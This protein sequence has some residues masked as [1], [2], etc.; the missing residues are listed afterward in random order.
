MVKYISIYFK[1][2]FHILYKTDRK[3]DFMLKMR[4]NSTVMLAAFVAMFIM[5]GCANQ[6]PDMTEDENALVT[7]Y[8][9]GLLLKYHADYEGR[10]VDTA[11]PPEEK[12]PVVPEQVVDEI[13]PE[14]SEVDTSSEEVIVS[15]NTIEEVVKPTMSIAQVIGTE[16]FDVK[17]RAFE[18]CDRYPNT[19]SSPEELFFSMK[20]GQGNKLL[21][22]KID[23]TNIG[24]EEMIF[25]TLEK[26]DMKCKV[27]INGSKKQ[28]VYISMLENDFMAMNHGIAPGETIEAAV[29]T[30]LPE[31][32]AQQITDA[33]LLI[34]NEGR[35]TEVSVAE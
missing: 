4:K 22:L 21:V 12:V 23:I 1:W 30:E 15:S 33:K 24:S 13:L 35:S 29:I 16:G 19:E 3:Q 7:E 5:T 20:A 6:I 28:N 8:A 10:L 34:E 18:V 9:A 11:V 31:T 14:Q 26:L 27:I 2:R 25:N 32:E 17:Y